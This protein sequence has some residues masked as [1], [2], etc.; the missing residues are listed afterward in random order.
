MCLQRRAKQPKPLNVNLGMPSSR[1]TLSVHEW[2]ASDMMQSGPG[3][4][5]RRCSTRGSCSMAQPFKKFRSNSFEGTAS[6]FSHPSGRPTSMLG[7]LRV[8][9]LIRRLDSTI[10]L[11]TL[12]SRLAFAGVVMTVT[13]AP[14]SASRQAMSTMGIMW[15][16]ANR[17]TKTK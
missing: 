1:A 5:F 11:M 6:K 12:S 4:C 17:G 7:N 15:P 10:L 8:T 2:P 13:I 9:N 14:W 16:W 3:R